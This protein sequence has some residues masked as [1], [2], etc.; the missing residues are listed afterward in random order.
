MT[1]KRLIELEPRLLA[2]YNRALAIRNGRRPFDPIDVWIGSR[3]GMKDEVTALVGWDRKDSTELGTN[4]AY[5][6]AY[7]K[8]FYEGLLG[9]NAETGVKIADTLNSN[10]TKSG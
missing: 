6:I 8:I 7:D 1:W 3:H 10:L 4:E 2:L 5:D 9:E